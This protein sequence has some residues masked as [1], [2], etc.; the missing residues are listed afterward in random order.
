MY[1][2]RPDRVD[3]SLAYDDALIRAH[4]ADAGLDLVTFDEGSW[5]GRRRPAGTIPVP[6]AD[7]YVVAPTAMPARPGV[8]AVS[9]R[10]GREAI[11]TVGGSVCSACSSTSTRQRNP[12]E[13]ILL[14]LAAGGLLWFIVAR[15]RRREE[16]REAESKGTSDD[17][18]FGRR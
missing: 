16:R 7:L 2:N 5:H 10:S 1:T 4:L 9:S 3:W 15:A 8:G 11:V 17:P 14:A 12:A 13:A 6:G 18:R